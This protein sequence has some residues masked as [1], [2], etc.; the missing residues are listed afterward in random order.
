[1]SKSSRKFRQKVQALKK[2]HD[3]PE[4][5]AQVIAKSAKLVRMKSKRLII[6]GPQKEILGELI[7]EGNDCCLR[8]FNGIL[9]LVKDGSVYMHMPEP[10]AKKKKKVDKKEKVK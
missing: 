2:L 6:F 5:E 1:M 8:P 9:P 4:V 3:I 10:V 7:I